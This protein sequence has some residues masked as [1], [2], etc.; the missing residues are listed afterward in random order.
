MCAIQPQACMSPPRAELQE[1]ISTPSYNTTIHYSFHSSSDSL[2][3]LE[4][5]IRV[6]F[7]TCMACGLGEFVGVKFIFAT[8]SA[9]S[10][11]QGIVH[12][13]STC[14][15][16]KFACWNPSIPAPAT[17]GSIM[18]FH[19]AALMLG[20]VAS[21]GATVRYD[22]RT[23]GVP[24]MLMPPGALEAEFARQNGGG[25]VCQKFTSLCQTACQCRS[26]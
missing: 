14:T 7:S 23:D 18:P 13:L 3:S 26:M 6:Y 19:V 8:T 17:T 16:R 24:V 25:P 20:A 2:I 15:K 1:N 10:G 11:N 22:L 12:F 4:L 9:P 21:T 5:A